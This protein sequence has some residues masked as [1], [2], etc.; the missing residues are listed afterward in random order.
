MAQPLTITDQVLEVLRLT[1]DCRLDDLVMTCRDY[2]WQGVLIEVNRLVRAG[3]LRLTLQGMGV[4]TVHL[5]KQESWV[6]TL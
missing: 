3:Q 6:E 2:S 4:F 1:P 5:A